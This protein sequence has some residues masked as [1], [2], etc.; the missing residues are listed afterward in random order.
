MMST[1]LP[2]TLRYAFVLH[3]SGL[4][5]AERSALELIEKLIQYGNIV[6]CI[7]PEGQNKMDKMLRIAG[8]QVQVLPSLTWWTS[9]LI[10]AIQQSKEIQLLLG[11]LKIDLVVTKTGTIPQAA[12]AARKLG[13]PHVWFLHEFLDVDHGLKVPFNRDAFSKIVLDYSD[14]VICNSNS[15]KE[16]F[17]PESHDKVVTAK[18]YPQIIDQM[19]A[20]VSKKMGT[21]LE[22][23]L[24]ANFN[25]GKGHLVLLAALAKLNKTNLNVRIKFFGDG[26]N[27]EYRGQIDSFIEQNSLL[28][29]VDFRGFISSRKEIFESIDAVV[30]PSLNEAFGRVP[31]EAMSYGVPVIYSA[32]GALTEYMIPN[33]T[34]IPFEV[35]DSNSLAASIREL[36]NTD[37][38]CS[39]L[40]RNGWTFVKNIHGAQSYI[41]DVMNICQAVV[42]NYNKKPLL[43]GIAVLIDELSQLTEQRDELT[44]QRDELTEQRDELTEQRDE[45]LNSTIW[46]VT[47]PIRTLIN[48]FKK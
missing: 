47:Q 19:E 14:K 40:V 20:P 10:M 32:S 4:G 29:K 6:N 21:P 17:F 9:D 45:L 31:F 13:I 12:I 15:V 43:D 39:F 7:V 27:S 25:P 37:Y 16:Y 5:G 18:P 34:G 1:E 2:H 24:I 46:K 41:S 22:L 11:K 30:V 48:L 28:E 23:G 42:Q 35:N 44:E 33:K 36:A 3:S 38:D 8:A 26:G